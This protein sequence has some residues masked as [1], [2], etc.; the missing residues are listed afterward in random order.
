MRVSYVPLHIAADFDFLVPH[1]AQWALTRGL[2]KACTGHHTSQPLRRGIG[3][4]FADTIRPGRLGASPPVRADSH[5]RSSV[6]ARPWQANI[7]AQC[8]F[9]AYLML[10]EL[11]CAGGG[12]LLQCSFVVQTCKP[13]AGDA[14][15]ARGTEVPS[16]TST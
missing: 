5:A 15:V 11:T 14:M 1:A 7:L 13:L 2:P 6:V 12:P 4:A 10:R 8:L 16:R 9:A 3:L